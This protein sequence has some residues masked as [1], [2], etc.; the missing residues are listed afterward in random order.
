MS[1]S[2]QTFF[3]KV[4]HRV[5]RERVWN[6]I[7][8]SHIEVLVVDAKKIQIIAIPQSLSGHNLILTVSQ[9]DKL[10]LSNPCVLNFSIGTE[11][12]FMR[13]DVQSKLGSAIAIDIN[14]E[15][16]KLQ[17]R[18][19]FRLV[20]PTGYKCHFDVKMKSGR[21]FNH[22]FVLAD[23]SG[24]GLA[25]EFSSSSQMELK[26]GEPMNGILTI[27][28]DFAEEVDVVIR[29]VRMVGSRGSGLCRVGA[30]FQ[31]L[32]VSKQEQIIKL[33]MDLHRELFSRMKQQT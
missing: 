18:E 17:R 31:S 19:S 13:I 33:V 8:G 25:F 32:K 1:S 22:S 6:T 9:P 30:E 11:K 10:P 16:Y 27:G 15:L 2:G 26:A 7:L 29:H 14:H 21:P 23:L 20:F 5:D 3:E 4:T 24:G 12:Y 28:K